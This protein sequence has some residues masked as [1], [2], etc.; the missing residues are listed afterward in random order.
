[1]IGADKTFGIAVIC[2]AH[3]QATMAAAINIGI[4]LMILTPGENNGGFA[5]KSLNEISWI[6]DLRFVPQK[7]PG[8]AEN[9]LLLKCIDIGVR[10]ATAANQGGICID[11]LTDGEFHISTN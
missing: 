3:G 4:D 7:Q 2:P 1:V 8:L 9:G 11:Q 6:F 10:P 5:H